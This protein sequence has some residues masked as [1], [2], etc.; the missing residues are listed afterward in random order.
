MFGLLSKKKLL[1]M[2]IK[3]KKKNNKIN[4]IYLESNFFKIYLF[5][6]IEHVRKIKSILRF[7]GSIT[8]FN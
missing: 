3:N 8:R 4:K 1:K 7:K 2:I 5:S 6:F